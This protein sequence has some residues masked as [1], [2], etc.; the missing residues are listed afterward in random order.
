VIVLDNEGQRLIAKYYNSP[1][2]LET[3]LLQKAFEKQL[4]QKSIKRTSKSSSSMEND[5]LNIENY[6]SVFRIYSD[7]SFYVLGGK[8]ENELCLS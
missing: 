8:D 1:Q 2:G 3:P 7:M 6:V 5:I 4:F